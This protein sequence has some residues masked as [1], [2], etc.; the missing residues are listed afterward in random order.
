MT[1]HDTNQFFGTTENILLSP[2]WEHI[3]YFMLLLTRNSY[4]CL[5]TLAEMIDCSIY[6]LV[7]YMYIRL[8]AIHV[9]RILYTVNRHL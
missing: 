1:S 9:L 7:T 3:F 8:Y 5:L 6:A 4:L 2:A